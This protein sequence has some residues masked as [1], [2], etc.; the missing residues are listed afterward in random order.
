MCL[1]AVL[2]LAAGAGRCS[3]EEILG[4]MFRKEEALGRCTASIEE[5][6]VLQAGHNQ[7]HK[8]PS[9]NT[10]FGGELVFRALIRVLQAKLGATGPHHRW[11]R[12]QGHV[13]QVTFG[14]M[15]PW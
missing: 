10:G 1:R 6:Q 2:L 14:K 7:V 11:V 12:H 9:S 13:L 5:A 4:R 15:S 3:E 8:S